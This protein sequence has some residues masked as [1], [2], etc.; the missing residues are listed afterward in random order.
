[1]LMMVLFLQVLFWALAFSVFALLVGGGI[2]LVIA[3]MTPMPLSIVL[4]ILARLWACSF[5]LGVVFG[6]GTIVGWREAIEAISDLD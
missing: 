3:W 2:S 6:L 4:Y 5:L 1:M